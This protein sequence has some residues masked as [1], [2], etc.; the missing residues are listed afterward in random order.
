MRGALFLALRSHRKEPRGLVDHDDIIV[1][2][3][4]FQAV[5]LDRCCRDLLARRNRHN[6]AGLQAGVV[7]DGSHSGDGHRAEAQKILG[8]LARQP[9]REGEQVWQ[10]FAL[11]RD[12]ELMVARGHCDNMVAHYR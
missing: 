3:D 2:I 1:E 4:D 11:R 10:Q 5:A 9:E 6:V 8:R 12:A 7:L